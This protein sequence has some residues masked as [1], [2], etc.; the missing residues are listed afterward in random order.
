MGVDLVQ[1]VRQFLGSV[2]L[3]AK[4]QLQ[5]GDGVIHAA[6]RVDAGRDGVA[7]I[8][9]G[10]GLARKADFLQKR[11]KAGAVGLLQLPQPGLDKGAV[12]PY[13]RHHVRHSAHSGKVAAV[14]QH[15]LRR[16]TV[17]R[18]TKLERH[19]RAAQTLE[20]AVVVLPAGVHHSH[21]LGQSLRRQMVVSDDQIHAQRSR[22]VGFFHGRDAVVHC[23]DE[24]AALVVHGLDGVFGQAVAVP[25]AA[26]QHTLD[27]RAHALEVLVQQGGSGHTVHIVIAEHGDGLAVVDG[28][29][30]ALTGGVHIRQQRGVGKFLLPCQQGQRFGGVGDAPGSKDARQQGVFLLLRSQHGLIFFV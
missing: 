25:L 16:A 13:Q 18:G 20:G 30:D 29:P 19:A 9:G 5:S 28:L 10:D 2:R 4:H 26:G 15:F 3:L 11:P 23:H 7:D 8:L 21:R 6:C 24:G 12:L 1:L 14:I 27:G 22:K 17:Q